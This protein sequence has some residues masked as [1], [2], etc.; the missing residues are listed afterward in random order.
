MEPIPLHEADP[1]NP[2]D[3]IME[4]TKKILIMVLVGLFILFFLVL[5]AYLLRKLA[6]DQA[7]KKE[8]EKQAQY[9]TI[10]PSPVQNLNKVTAAPTLNLGFQQILNEGCHQLTE[11][12][13]ISSVID[14]NR[15]PIIIDDNLL[16]SVNYVSGSN[17][18]CYGTGDSTRYVEI[19]L[20]DRQKIRLYDKNSKEDGHGGSP[21]LGL[22]GLMAKNSGD[23]KIN[24][25]LSIA[26]EATSI[27]KISLI[28]RGQKTI[29]LNKNE[30]IYINF[31]ETGIAAGN[32]Q[33]MTILDKYSVPSEEY[34]GEKELQNYNGAQTE[35][36]SYFFKD[37]N[38]L[39]PK[40]SQT[41]KIIE[42]LLN[43]IGGDPKKQERSQ[44]TP[45][46]SADLP[47][48]PTKTEMA[49]LF[50]NQ[51]DVQNFVVL[52]V[53]INS[54]KVFLI[55]GVDDNQAGIPYFIIYDNTSKKTLY[56]STSQIYLNSSSQMVDLQTNQDIKI[57]L[58]YYGYSLT[59]FIGYNETV[60]QFAPKNLQHRDEIVKTLA[61]INQKS[62]CQIV[63]NG[64]QVLMIDIKNQY[65]ENQACLN[66][67]TVKEYFRI[68]ALVESILQGKD[69][70]IID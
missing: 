41:I 46:L 12:Q 39:G 38:N 1:P 66:G 4:K 13:N 14:I 37:L 50:P 63:K 55:K 23:T 58:N 33:L 28:L 65:G 17:V 51:L 36:V 57:S 30:E 2:Q 67:I 6:I 61:N 42:D 60:Q 53:N 10:Q 9:K 68:K 8:L 44:I 29:Y 47:G 34:P 15:L 32:N 24:A 43:Q 45:T 54:N 64:P 48:A 62:S 21:F 70:S 40:I 5:I 19:D 18:Y 3:A 59:E 31:E 22:Y 20:K 35:A 25:Y 16:Q 27:K 7:Q 52:P 26:E 49:S 69:L 56:Q 11:N